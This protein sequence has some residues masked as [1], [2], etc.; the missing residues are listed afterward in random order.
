MMASLA[1]VYSLPWLSTYRPK[2]GTTSMTGIIGNC[3]IVLLLSSALPV[4]ARTL[5]IT[6]F[7]LLGEY[8]RLDWI[9]NFTVIMCYNIVFAALTILSLVNKFTSPV[10]REIF[11]RFYAITRRES[12]S[13]DGVHTKSD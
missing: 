13:N 2:K 9:S 11:R 12:L 4:L 8:G 7:D 6:S 5:G 3:A 10:R 1:G